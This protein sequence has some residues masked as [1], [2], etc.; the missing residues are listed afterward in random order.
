LGTQETVGRHDVG[1]AY[2]N[3]RILRLHQ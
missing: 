3:F 1:L 2:D